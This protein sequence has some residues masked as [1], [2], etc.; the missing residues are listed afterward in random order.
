MSLLMN[1]RSL[2]GGAAGTLLSIPRLARGQE[3]QIVGAG[4]SFVRPVMQRWIERTPATLGV[5]ASYTAIGTGTAQTRILGGD[6]DFA[7]VELPLPADKVATGGLLQ[8]PVAF[9]SLV[10]VAT[11]PGIKKDQITLTG[12][13]LGGIYGG[14]IKMWNDPRIAAVNPGVSLP[15]MEIRPIRLDTPSGSVFSTTFTFTQY[16]LQTNADWR[17]KHGEVVS[18]RWAVGS[19]ATSAEYMVE[20]LDG[21]P[22][23][24][25]YVPLG[26]AMS[27]GMTTLMMKN[28]S[29]KAV[30][31]D[32]ASLRATVA[33]VDWAATPGMAPKL[34]DLSGGRTWPIVLASYA[35]IQQNP[36]DQARGAA[37]R[38]FLKFAV[39]EGTEAAAL[40]FAADL[41]AGPR[42]A[43]LALL[44]RQS[45]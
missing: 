39:S 10:C 14:T 4:S 43:V 28:K 20:S 11:L 13:L 35:L 24:I 30:S 38:K 5:K 34:L 7:A 3:T 31:A 22:G 36:A 26:L 41:P 44:E 12:T 15:E 6:L 42:A 17:E 25:G 37:V 32:L 45:T 33:Q 1:R 18:R 2:M 40:A 8:F 27:R 16:L 21:M 9:G 29:G 23:G 19:M